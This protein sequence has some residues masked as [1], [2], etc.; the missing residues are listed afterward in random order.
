MGLAW[1]YANRE[2]VLAKAKTPEERARKRAY[3]ASTIW[4]RRELDMLR[5]KRNRVKRIA[6]MREYW[7]RN[8]TKMQAYKKEYFQRTYPLRKQEH[9]AAGRLDRKKHHARFLATQRKWQRANRDKCRLYESRY[10]AKKTG[11]R[12]AKNNRRRVRVLAAKTDG[13]AE[14]FIKKVRSTALLPCNYCGQIISGKTA[15]IDHMMPLS[16]G[17]SHTA[18]NLCAA[19]EFCNCSKCDRTLAEWIPPI[20]RPV[21]IGI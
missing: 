7:A 6:K 21:L 19:C 8:R 14:A 20:K 3:Y 15:H 18:D 17:G 1:Y 12:T 5:H 2:K 9:L 16:K 13:T 10:F 11:L 4:R